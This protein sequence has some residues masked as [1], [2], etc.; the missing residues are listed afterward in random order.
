MAQRTA[1][2]LELRAPLISHNGA[3]IKEPDDGRELLHLRIATEAA[4]E[5]ATFCDEGGFETYTTVDGLT[6]IRGP[7]EAQIDPQRLPK[8][9][10]IARTHAE[11]V[12]APA[13]GII[14]FND[15]A[16]RAV[17][18]AFAARYA[19]VL[20]FPEAW[21]EALVPYVTITDA[22]AD[23]GRALRLVCQHLGVPPEEAMAVGDTAQDVPM[24]EAAGLGVAM[25]NAPE[26]VKARADAVAPSNAEG[27]VG[28]AIRRFV[29]EEG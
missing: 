12:T 1:R 25:G 15:E 23:K 26:D 9:M 10:L 19:G 17:I 22:G 7:W 28:W 4:R 24:F 20:A 14:V 2:Q 16:V 13:T 3:Y 21:S 29:L 5:I 6:Y 8:D 11:Y 18:D 27:G